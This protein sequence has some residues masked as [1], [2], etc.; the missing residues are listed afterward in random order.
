MFKLIKSA[1]EW[2]IL[3]AAL[4]YKQSQERR[5]NHQ[6]TNIRYRRK[7]IEDLK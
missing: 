6:W 3:F 1:K 7:L 5:R 4:R 2:S